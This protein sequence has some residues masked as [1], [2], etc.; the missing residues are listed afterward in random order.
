MAVQLMRTDEH[1]A[2]YT[3]LTDLQTAME[4]YL[5]YFGTYAVDETAGTITHYVAGASFVGYRDSVQ[6]RA[7]AFSDDGDSLQLTAQSPVDG[8]QRVLLWARVAG[9]RSR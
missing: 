6:H 3:D 4:G 7:F 8:S 5:G 1:A 2:A 9:T